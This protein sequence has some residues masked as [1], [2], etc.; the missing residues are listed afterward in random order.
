MATIYEEER[1]ALPEQAKVR[2]LLGMCTGLPVVSAA[3]TALKVQTNIGVLTY[4]QAVNHIQ[5][6]VSQDN[7]GPRFVAA[8]NHNGGRGRGCV[9]QNEGEGSHRCRTSSIGRDGDDFLPDNEWRKLTPVERWKH[10]R[11]RKAKQKS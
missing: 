11:E 7:A 3:V 6:V 4:S 8:L 1:E 10:I 9:G 2:E 5:S